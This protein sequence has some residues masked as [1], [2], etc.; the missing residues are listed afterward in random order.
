MLLFILLLVFAICLS[1]NKG[2]ASGYIIPKK[3]SIL[4]KA[5]FGFR[6]GKGNF[7]RWGISKLKNTS[8]HKVFAFIIFSVKSFFS[9]EEFFS[10]LVF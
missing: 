4:A 7:I 10:I 2:F 3:F 6:T 1:S 5:L 8:Y 9:I